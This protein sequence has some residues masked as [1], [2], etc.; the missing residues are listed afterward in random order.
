M[1]F[2]FFQ[3]EDGIRDLV[4]SRGLGDVYKRQQRR[5]R[6]LL[7]RERWLTP[8]TRLRLASLSSALGRLNAV[9]WW[10]K[11]TCIA[12]MLLWL[13]VTGSASRSPRRDSILSSCQGQTEGISQISQK[14]NGQNRNAVWNFPI[15]VVY[16]ST[17]AFGWPQL[18]LSV[19]YINSSG[20][21]TICGYGRMHLPVSPGRCCVFV[22]DFTPFIR[23]NKRMH[24]FTP[25]AS[26]WVQGLASWFSGTPPEFVNFK[27]LS[28]GEGREGAP[29]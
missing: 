17:N 22:F 18:I 7:K 23:Y 26:S 12:D 3:A 24:L 14:G 25:M 6:G 11:T 19:S 28:E 20:K 27:F 15:D 8:L 2:F 4:R 21:D 9:R 5:V 10:G 29:S 13:A 1:L 16:N